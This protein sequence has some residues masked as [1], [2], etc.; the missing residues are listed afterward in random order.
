MQIHAG[1]PAGVIFELLYE[2]ERSYKVCVARESATGKETSWRHGK[3]F[4]VG[5]GTGM[6]IGT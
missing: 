6:R 2:S 3:Y 5:R 4:L 1:G